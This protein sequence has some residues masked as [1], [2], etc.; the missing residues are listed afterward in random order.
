MDNANRSL[1]WALMQLSA[2][3]FH[4]RNSIW[5]WRLRCMSR[6]NLIAQ[7]HG[8]LRVT[9]CRVIARLYNLFRH[10]REVQRVIEDNIFDRQL[11]DLYVFR[12]IVNARE[13]R[14]GK[15]ELFSQNNFHFY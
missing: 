1:G 3:L 10:S 15:S 9:G 14:L 6:E 11:N 12:S 13:D 7:L 2:R 5:L 4:G 8:L